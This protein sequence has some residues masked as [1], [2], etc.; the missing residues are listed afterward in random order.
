MFETGDLY[1][2]L[3]LIISKYYNDV[4]TKVL[5]R[6]TSSTFLIKGLHQKLTMEVKSIIVKEKEEVVVRCLVTEYVDSNVTVRLFIGGSEQNDIHPVVN[7]LGNRKTTE[8]IFIFIANRDQ[9][10]HE[11]KCCVL[12]NNR[13]SGMAKED[14]LNILCE[15]TENTLV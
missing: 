11:I 14:T 6:Y 8:F 7:S 15:Y 1:K 3:N 4:K 9:N 13:C 12:C 10:G 5:S 2:K